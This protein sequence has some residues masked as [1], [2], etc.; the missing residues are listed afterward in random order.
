MVTDA[1][2]H[3]DEAHR[4]RE[5]AEARNTA[6]QLA[7]QTEKQLAEHR[8]KLD[9]SDAGDD[10]GADHGAPPGARDATISREINA[11]TEALEEAFAAARRGDLRPGAASRQPR[12][13]PPATAAAPS[14][15]EVVEDADYEVID[16]D[17]AAKTS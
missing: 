8:D 14:D 17:E 1:E 11:K 13:R 9:A 15:D 2:A 12:P 3:A 7:Y 10:R 5:L 6:E 16:E 4:L